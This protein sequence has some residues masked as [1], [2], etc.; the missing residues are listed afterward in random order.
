MNEMFDRKLIAECATLLAVCL[1][2]WLLIVRPRMSTLAEL[3][4]KI[5][6][7]RS[8]PARQSR[9]TVEQLAAT[10]DEVRSEVREITR[11]NEL[12]RDSSRMY[13]LIMDLGKRHHVSVARL[14]PGTQGAGDD[15]AVV[16][17][18]WS[19]SV[20]GRYRQVASFL[21][22][23]LSIDGFVRP[24][25]LTLSPEGTAGENALVT[26][27]FSCEALSFEIPEALVSIVGEGDADE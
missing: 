12:G 2:A 9:Q 1:G 17:T 18:G 16:K 3:E 7:A 10:L 27:Q 23:I 8:D 4:A 20:S 25:S 5:E 13:G 14:D 15:P 11:Q 21:D 19:M 6:E 22:G 26:A 24:G